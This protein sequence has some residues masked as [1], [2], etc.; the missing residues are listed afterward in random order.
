MTG[1]TAGAPAA[2]A[3]PGSRRGRWT[4]DSFWRW[5]AAAVSVALVARLGWVSYAGHHKPLGLFDPA[6]YAAY[7]GGIARGKGYVELTGQPTAYYPPGYPWFLGVIA[8]VQ[9]HGPFGRSLPLAAGVVQAVLGAATAAFAAVI[10]RRLVSPRAG[11]L[12]AFGIALYPNLVFHTAALLSETL[13]NFLFLAFLAALL[14]EPWATG[15]S[16]RRVAVVAV[17]FSLAVL[18]RPISLAVLPVLLIAWWSSTR[19]WGTALRLTA[20]TFAVVFALILPW[21]VR[22]AVR[23]HALI[24]LST[25]TGDNL[26]IGHHPG[27]N[28][29]FDLTEACNS[30]EGVQ[31]GTRS[32]VRNDRLKTRQA[33]SYIAHH[34][35]R[36]PWLVTRRAYYM[37]KADDDALTAVQSYG[38]DPWL[39]PSARRWL[40]RLANGVY[41]IVA[42][43]SV[44]GLVRLTLS[45]RP[46]ALLLVLSA[47]VT[48]TVPLAFFG[49]PRFKVP[50]IP[51][52]VI[53]A[54]AT[55]SRFE[56]ESAIGADQDV[57]REGSNV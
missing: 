54:A 17:P 56:P 1:T 20:V 47:L 2:A 13:Y 33:L 35:G 19:S 10:G 14:A 45:G 39:S 52:L 30:G 50:V 48:V 41:V 22:N 16:T 31:F 53:A 25:N 43:V 23:M 8:W 51:L 38:T 55:V 37:F 9:S 34:L 26:C 6:R 49:D 24:P 40:S 18:V 42:L 7:A 12:A 5:T 36:E 4:H 3:R 44:V 28:G 46:V 32:E 15:L 57:S 11:I 29:A 21:T 27:A